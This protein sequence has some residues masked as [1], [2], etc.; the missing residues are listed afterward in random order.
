MTATAWQDGDWVEAGGRAWPAGDRGALLGDGLFETVRIAQGE[1]VAFERHMARL[2]RSC[3]A[4]DLPLPYDATRLQAAA[5]ELATRCKLAEAALR[6][7]LSA[8]SG[9]RGLDRPGTLAVSVRMTIAPLPVPPR[10]IGLAFATVRRSPSSFCA[11]HKTLSYADNVIARRQARAA[12]A[13]MAL[14]LDT[15]GHLSGGDSANVFWSDDAGRLFTPSLDCAVLPGT[16]RARIV[17]AL[18]VVEGRYPPEA[19]FTAACVFVTNAL[20]GAVPA[21]RLDGQAVGS[22]LAVFEKVKGLLD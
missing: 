16:A 5:G 4:L 7:T 17:E 9:P 20:A 2:H 12:G 6:L 21:D 19:L 10:R 11:S 15:N 3:A 13:D 14:L 18:P 1:P 8:G 22:R